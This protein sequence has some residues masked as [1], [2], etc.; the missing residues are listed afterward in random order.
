MCSSWLVRKPDDVTLTGTHRPG[1]PGFAAGATHAHI[2]A[3]A[4][5]G[6]LANAGLGRDAPSPLVWALEGTG[7]LYSELSEA[8]VQ[9]GEEVVDSCSF[10]WRRRA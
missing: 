8:L 4:G 9:A 7:S 10:S 6:L 5:G 3:T 2:E 1:V